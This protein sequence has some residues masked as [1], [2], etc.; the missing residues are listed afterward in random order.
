[1][2]ISNAIWML[3]F[4]RL[5]GSYCIFNETKLASFQMSH[6]ADYSDIE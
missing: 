4:T 2:E 6:Y 5:A 3:L 1:M